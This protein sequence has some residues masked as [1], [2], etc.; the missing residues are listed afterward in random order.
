MAN[1]WAIWQRDAHTTYQLLS[2]SCST[3]AI[4]RGLSPNINICE[5]SGKGQELYH[6][7]KNY[8]TERARGLYRKTRFLHSNNSCFIPSCEWIY[9]FKFNLKISQVSL[10]NA[11]NHYF[12]FKELMTS[13]S[14]HLTGQN[15][16]WR[17]LG[18]SPPCSTYLKISARVAPGACR[19]KRSAWGLRTPRRPPG[20]PPPSP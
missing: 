18:S 10:N 8:Q 5:F 19:N 17:E 7:Q 1:T 3:R 6:Q 15:I 14:R 12:G 20:P 2:P 11:I 9:L 4:P 16:C 13:Q